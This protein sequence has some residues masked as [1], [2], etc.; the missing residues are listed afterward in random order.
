MQ[1]ADPSAIPDDPLSMRRQITHLRH[2]QAFNLRINRL[3]A[4]LPVVEQLVSTTAE[5]FA[6]RRVFAL[7]ID[8]EETR[9]Q[10]VSCSVPL[11]PELRQQVESLSIPLYAGDVSAVLSRW[12]EGSA[13]AVTATDTADTVASLLQALQLKTVYSQPLNGS[14]GLIGAV[15]TE[16][17]G[18]PE[19]GS[20]EQALLKD[21]AESAAIAL[22]NARGHNQALQRMADEMG[23]L[24]VLQQIDRE[25]NETISLDTVFS[26]TLDWALRFSNANA[27]SIALYDDATGSL[28]TMFHYGYASEDLAERLTNT[29]ISLRVARSGE[30]E[31]LPYVWLDDDLLTAAHHILSQMAVPIMREDRV[32]AVLTMESRKANAFRENH[33]D[34][35]LKLA[36]RAAVAI[37]NARLYTESVREREKLSGILS[38]LAEVVI[39][40]DLEGR[41]M[42]M[43]QSA[44]SALQLYQDR[45]YI[46]QLFIDAI[47]FT[48]LVNIYRRVR[49]SEESV[50]EE[51]VLPN[52]RTFYTNAALF[53]G[54]G[55]IIVM[56][57]VTPYK[58][59][60]RLKGELIATV[61]HDLKQPLS[62]MMGYLDLLQMKNQFNEQSQNFVNMIDR[63]IRSM[64]Q[65]IDD[66]L[67]MARI[68]SGMT[69]DM[70][71]VL[72]REVLNECI[73]MNEQNARLKSIKLHTEIP[74]DLPFVDGERARLYQVFN[75]L[76][77]NAIK[78]TH[79]E[80]KVE[81]KA[82]QR[83][84]I[85]RISIKDNGI[86]ISPEDQAHIFERFYR[87]RRPETDS[88]EGTGLGLAIVKTLVEAHH[89]KIR[90]ES[91]LNE[92][93]TFYVTLPVSDSSY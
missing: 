61:S 52:G 90:V 2:V 15:L 8:N 24:N 79:P 58:E 28:R 21:I 48:P 47:G 66:L 78:Y 34:F 54:I 89:G 43:N 42:M 30:A 45:T 64:R 13:I 26:M 63:S 51:L 35:A 23:M 73:T 86:G 20:E 77:S 91:M 29:K 32:I 10:L 65:L 68:E 56:Q 11:T 46:G 41:V 92:G 39:V 62:I 33:L 1:T 84:S 27:G 38:N 40:I 36:T 81:V 80:G 31:I 74:G 93:S 87:V 75:N 25:L 6:G 70:Q 12:K 71:P 37:D 7:M 22:Q 17:E 53:Q 18:K 82:E 72:L 44:M 67:D 14:M 4:P 3:S 76:V 59:M 57:D 50:T 5:L 60:D 83:G 19:I 88:I 69:L 9:L 16:T 85:I 49:T 55:C